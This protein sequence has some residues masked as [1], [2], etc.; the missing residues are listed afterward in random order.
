[1]FIGV[2]HCRIKLSRRQIPFDLTIP[3]VGDELLEPFGKTREF[4]GRK[5][6]NS[7]FDFFNVHVRKLQPTPLPAKAKI[8]LLNEA[9]HFCGAGEWVVVESRETLSQRLFIRIHDRSVVAP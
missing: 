2:L 1:M 6:G 7:R 8:L 9:P 3:L 5:S 4:G